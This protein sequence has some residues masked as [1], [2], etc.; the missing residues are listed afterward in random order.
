MKHFSCFDCDLQLGGQRYVMK[1]DKPYCCNCFE[2]RFSEFCVTCGS[3]IGVD[4][5]QMTHAGQHW[6]AT[7]D[8][9]RCATCNRALLGHPFLPKNR[10]I[11]CSVDCSRGISVHNSFVDSANDSLRSG[12]SNAHSDTNK[13]NFE[14]PWVLRDTARRE[15]FSE[16]YGSLQKPNQ[17]TRRS[18]PDLTTCDE[19]TDLDTSRP[20]L[21]P[22][23]RV[24]SE[25]NLR[26][27]HK[28]GRKSMRSKTS[29]RKCVQWAN[30]SIGSEA[31]NLEWPNSP[32]ISPQTERLV[33]N[34][35]HSKSASTSQQQIDTKPRKHRTKRMS[36]SQRE[37]LAQRRA[38]SVPVDD[39]ADSS[40]ST[41]TSSSGEDSELD[42]AYRADIIKSGG[43]RVAYAD[44]MVI[45]PKKSL[46]TCRTKKA[47]Q[48]KTKNC[49]IQ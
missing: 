22:K 16:G 6:H 30:Q 44:N 25:H 24:G 48:H 33:S 20:P 41:C 7:E 32:I 26:H 5:G 18:L 49:S 11:Y 15:N 36:R 31:N 9:F 43:L 34:F 46:A 1:E 3:Q 39:A 35:A 23:T 37:K 4:Q 27:I 8:C 12:C 19:Y 29:S 38:T 28:S 17:T 45:A 2:Q 14:D 13:Q 10:L 21:P 40:C 42:D 47:K